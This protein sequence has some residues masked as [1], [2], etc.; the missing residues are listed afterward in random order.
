M[1]AWRAR[2]AVEVAELYDREFWRDADA[3]AGVLPEVAAEELFDKV[4]AVPVVLFVLL[5][6]DEDDTAAAAAA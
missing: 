4:P 1:F 3:G 6:S 2:R 5:L